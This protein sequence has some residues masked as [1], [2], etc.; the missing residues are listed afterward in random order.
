[1]D[2][3]EFQRLMAET[4]IVNSDD[5]RTLHW[6]ECISRIMAATG[7][8]RKKVVDL[9]FKRF[10]KDRKKK[11]S[12]DKPITQLVVELEEIGF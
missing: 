2:D 4:D 8:E 11:I 7:L 12:L 10:E 5:R 9:V 6:R 1:M 3:A